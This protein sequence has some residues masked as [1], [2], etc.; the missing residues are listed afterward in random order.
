VY[1]AGPAV[2]QGPMNVLCMGLKT[3]AGN[4]VVDSEIRQCFSREDVVTAAGDGSQLAL[5]GIAALKANPNCNLF[6]I[7]VTEAGGG[8]AATVTML[9]ATIPTSDGTITV[10]VAGASMNVS[11]AAGTAID[12]IGANLASRINAQVDCPVTASYSAGS[13]TL[14]L[15]SKN[16]GIGTKDII[17]Y[18]D[19]SLSGGVTS[20]MTGSADVNVFGQIKGVRMGAA[21]G[22]GTEDYTTA[23]TKIQTKRYARIA[24]GTNDATNAALVETTVNNLAAVTVQI[25]DQFMFGHNGTQGQATT[26]AQTTLNAP[27]AQVYAYR[28]SETPPWVIAGGW[29]AVRAATEGDDPVPDYDNY[30][31]SA[32]IFPTQFDSDTWLPTEENALLNAGV[33]PIKTENAAPKVVRS[34]TTYCLN[35]AVQDT[36]TLDIGDAVFPDY[37]YFDLQNLYGTFR[38]ANKYAEPDPDIAAGDT[39]PVAGVAYPQLWVKTVIGLMYDW[40]ANGWIEDTFSGDNPAYPVQ[41]SWNKAARRIQSNVPFVV[42]RVIHQLSV[43]ARQTAPAA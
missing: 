21:G 8:T 39:F 13:D 2:G 6:L 33:T 4:L 10:R 23:L 32:W 27:R 3:S 5:M 37:A 12:T 14:T 7:A 29:A 24:V 16:V 31:C 19:L 25:Y 42:N 26:L 17:V 40:R 35:G 43:I 41:A 15:T 20:T 22:T 36:R 11:Y 28:N 18:Q 34:I 30:D 1:A 9:L 38:E